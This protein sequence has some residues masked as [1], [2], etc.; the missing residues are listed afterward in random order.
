[1]KNETKCYKLEFF[2]MSLLL[3]YE[4]HN[5]GFVYLLFNEKIF[6]EHKLICV[7][8][9][10]MCIQLTDIESVFHTNKMDN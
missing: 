6:T 1:M 9:T 7:T 2:V 5:N 3:V 10:V 8:C 4:S